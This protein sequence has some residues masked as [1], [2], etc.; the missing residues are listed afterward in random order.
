MANEDYRI[1]AY[2][3]VATMTPSDVPVEGQEDFAPNVAAD[4]VN[5]KI[6]YRTMHNATIRCFDLSSINF[7]KVRF[8]SYPLDKEKVQPLEQ[9]SVK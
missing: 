4:L 2:N 6:Y 7:E 1:Q 5:R 3:R 8:Q 9:I